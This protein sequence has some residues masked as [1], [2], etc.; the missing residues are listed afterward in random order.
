M[1][2]VDQGP[3]AVDRHAVEQPFD[4]PQPGPG[5]AFGDF[6]FLLGDVDVNGAFGADGVISRQR[7]RHVR[8][9]DGAQAVQGGAGGLR[10]R[11][12]GQGGDDPGPFVDLQPEA[13]LG[14][15][16]RPAAEAAL[17]I[18]DRQQRQPQAGRVRACRD[19]PGQFR[20]IAVA[21]A[22]RWVVQIVELGD[23]GVAGLQHLDIEMGRDRFDLRRREALDETVHGP[24]PRPEIR[25]F[26]AARPFGQPGHGALEGMAVQVR[27][28]GDD[29]AGKLR[30]PAGGRTGFDPPDRTCVVHVQ[31]HALRP[32]G[33]QQAERAPEAGK[34]AGHR[35]GALAGSADEAAYLPSGRYTGGAFRAPADREA[36]S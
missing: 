25:P 21:A 8:R 18:Q 17:A 6:L 22:V 32:A 28:A 14:R 15:G 7:V 24:A 30:V 12:S 20:A 4:R 27:H 16:E 29:R 35:C 10:R 31:Q 2:G 3:A 26:L 5:E 36:R 34:R 13:P 33:R 19:A 9:Q 1:G 11:R 23:A